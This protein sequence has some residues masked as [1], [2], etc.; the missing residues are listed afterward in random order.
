[1]TAISTQDRETLRTLA[2]RWMEL[3]HLPVM[4]VEAV[5]SAAA[6]GLLARVKPEV[7]A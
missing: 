5:F 3:A 7:L 6:I 2:Q 1:M 4:A